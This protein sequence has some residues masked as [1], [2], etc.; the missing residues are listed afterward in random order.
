MQAYGGMKKPELP[1][2]S[3]SDAD[4]D[5]VIGLAAPSARDP[6]R[7]KLMAR[8]DED[9]RRALVSDDAVFEHVMADDEAFV[10]VTPALYFEVLLRRALA[11]LEIATH[12]VERSGR[13][14]IPVFDTDDVVRLMEAPGV[15]EYLAAMLASFT[16][17]ESYVR[18]VRV[19]RGVW[20]KVRYNDMDVDSL[21]RFCAE[22]DEQQRLP[23]YKR[24]AD[25][26]LFV[27]GIFRDYAP[28]SSG[29]AIGARRGRRTLED[30]E[31]EGRRFYGLAAH[32]PGAHALGLSEVFDLLREHFTSARK[33]LAF[34]ASQYLHSR[35]NRLF[36]APG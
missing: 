11:E 9:F 13:E 18:P 29:S 35:R 5:F 24:I 25:V 31:V 28:S 4:L 30:Y 14:A 34:I 21:L 16:R 32:H 10:H 36:A 12:T 7:L 22:A 3:L 19:R 2:A 1:D 27:T 33:P 26:C 20:R 6:E 23:F 15:P 8:Q 17:V